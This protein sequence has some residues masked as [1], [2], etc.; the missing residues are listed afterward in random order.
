MTSA[1]KSTAESVTAQ[2]SA[3]AE[4]VGA[5]AET[6]RDYATGYVQPDSLP[7]VENP[8]SRVENPESTTVYI[9]NLFFDVTAEDLK[10]E[11][12]RAGNVDTAKIIYDTRGLSKG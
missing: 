1:I 10:N 3:A 11:F 8:E 4:S 2:A 5:A 6:A 12:S 9:G 7:R